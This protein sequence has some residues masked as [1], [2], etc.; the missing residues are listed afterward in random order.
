[1]SSHHS[2]LPTSGAHAASASKAARPVSAIGNFISILPVNVHSAQAIDQLIMRNAD[3]EN[4]R[5]KKRPANGP[6]P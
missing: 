4:N 6:F 1:M 3:T 5:D 2:T